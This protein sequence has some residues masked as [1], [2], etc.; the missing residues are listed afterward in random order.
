MIKNILS[1]YA[2]QLNEFLS[3]YHHRP[4]GLAEIG[5]IGKIDNAVPNKML[6]SLLNLERETSG[7][8]SCS[9]QRTAEGGYVRMQPSLQ[10][11][12]NVMIAAVYDERQ[13]AESLSVLSDTLRFIQSHLSFELDGTTYT[14]EV[15]NLTSQDMNNLWSLM[16]SQYYPSV[17][18][19]VRHININT[20]EIASSNTAINNPVVE[21]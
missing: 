8:I 15:I 18:V 13:Y 11:N 19:K 3:R 20:E 9:V 17:V 4:E 12:L 14:V 2:K 1:Y 16:G 7:G 5:R 10:F 6:V 21:L